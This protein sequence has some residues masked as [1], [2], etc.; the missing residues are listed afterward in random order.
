MWMAQNSRIIFREW[1][2]TEERWINYSNAFV[3]LSS[4]RTHTC[5]CRP[6]NVTVKVRTKQ[7]RR[8]Q[9]A[10]GSRAPPGTLHLTLG[11]HFPTKIQISSNISQVCMHLITKSWKRVGTGRWHTLHRFPGLNM[12]LR[13]RSQATACWGQGHEIFREWVNFI[14][15]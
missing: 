12:T 7:G 6:R 2:L 9:R 13:K 1:F 4:R 11:F 8:Y 15:H 14:W 5:N 10:W 3:F